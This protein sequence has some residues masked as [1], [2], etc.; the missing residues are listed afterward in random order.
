M[1]LK[2]LILAA[3]YGTRLQRDILA[4]PTQ[5]FKNRLNTPKPLLPLGPNNDALLTY[6]LNIF[7]EAKIEIATAVFIVTNALY[8]PQF[9]S[10]AQEQGVP[11]QNIVS[12]GTETNETRVGAVGDVAFAVKHFGWF[13]DTWSKENVDLCIIA[14][15]TLFQKGFPFEKLWRVYEKKCKKEYDASLVT[16]HHV[17]DEEVSKFGILSLEEEMEEPEK[18]ISRNACPCFYFFRREMV[19][20]LRV[21]LQ[22]SEQRGDPL[23]KRD[24]IGKVLAWGIN[25]GLETFYAV[26]VEGRIDV[27]DLQGYIEARKYFENI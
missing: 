15:D 2:I 12:D 13:K 7:R 17:S 9:V 11:T 23:D 19:G 8:Y 14:G 16:T 26:R 3:G 5:Q 10:W 20:L 1:P 6:W 18:T 22:E 21:F 27:G 4:D 24:A 25:G